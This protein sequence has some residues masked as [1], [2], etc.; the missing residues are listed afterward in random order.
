MATTLKKEKQWDEPDVPLEDIPDNMRIVLRIPDVEIATGNI[1]SDIIIR[2]LGVS[3]LETESSCPSNSITE[4]GLS[5][6]SESSNPSN[7][8]PDSNQALANYLV[9][10]MPSTIDKDQSLSYKGKVFNSQGEQIRASSGSDAK[11]LMDN[12]EELKEYVPFTPDIDIESRLSTECNEDSV[13]AVE[14]EEEEPF[15]VES[16]V[17]KKFNTKLGQ[18]EFLVKWKGYSA[19]HNTWELINNI[20]ESIVTKFELDATKKAAEPPKRPGLRD[21][22]T[23]KAKSLPEYLSND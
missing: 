2:E 14:F 12:I 10:I 11:L 3:S 5:D 15:N 21:R 23:I 13:E 9:D 7:S 8:A 1:I 17:K 4:T 18:Y 6:A 19:K 22:S 20:P 16:I